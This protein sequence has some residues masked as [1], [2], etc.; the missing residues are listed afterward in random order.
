MSITPEQILTFRQNGF[1]RI[2]QIISP[3]EVQHFREVGT[4]GLENFELNGANEDISRR[5][6]Q[7]VNLWLKEPRFKALS[8]HPN[9]TRA[10]KALAGCEL[11]LFH[12][13]LLCKPPQNGAATEWHQDRPYWPIANQK[14]SLSAWVALQDTNVEMGCMSFIPASHTL[15]ALPSTDLSSPKAFFEVAPECEFRQSV[16]VPL[17]AGDCTFHYGET[18]HRASPNLT[19]QWRMA[20][21]IIYIDADS[22]YSGAVH[23]VTDPLQAS[24]ALEPMQVFAHDHFP[25]V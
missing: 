22:Q 18:A 19:D 15:R 5:L 24:G 17:K 16:T 21:T 6:T 20:H 1:I 11:R 10:A 2:P 23:V 12:D 9:I 7:I 14:V 3:K 13:H 25:R 4:H 8:L